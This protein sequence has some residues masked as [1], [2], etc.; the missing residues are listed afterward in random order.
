MFHKKSPVRKEGIVFH[1]EKITSLWNTIPMFIIFIVLYITNTL[2]NKIQDSL[3]D[4]S[5]ISYE[6]WNGDSQ[7]LFW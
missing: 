7:P 6:C 1:N 5:L 3:S 4:Q 2:L